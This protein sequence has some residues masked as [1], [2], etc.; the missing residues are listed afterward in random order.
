MRRL[1][2]RWHEQSGVEIPFQDP[3]AFLQG[4]GRGGLVRWKEE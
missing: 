4:R 2:E 1:A 3:E